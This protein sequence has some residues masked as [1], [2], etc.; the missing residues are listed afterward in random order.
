MALDQEYYEKALGILLTKGFSNQE[1]DQ[2]ATTLSVYLPM[3]F[4]K[5]G[6]WAL[7]PYDQHPADPLAFK[8]MRLLD[9]IPELKKPVILQMPTDFTYTTYGQEYCPGADA[10]TYTTGPD[11]YTHHPVGWESGIT[12]MP[13]AMGPAGDDNIEVSD[14][15]CDHPQGD[16]RLSLP[17]ES[18]VS[19]FTV[20]MRVG[21]KPIKMTLE[22][23]IQ[24]IGGYDKLPASARAAID[25][26]MEEHRNAPVTTVSVRTPLPGGVS[27]E[28]ADYLKLG[29]LSDIEGIKRA[30]PLIDEKTAERMSK[31]HCQLNQHIARVHREPRDVEV[32]DLLAGDHSQ[33]MFQSRHAKRQYP[34]SL[35][36]KFLPDQADIDEPEGM[37]VKIKTHS[38]RHFG[39]GLEISTPLFGQS[40]K[41]PTGP[42][43]MPGLEKGRDGKRKRNKKGRR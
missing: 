40:H 34:N 10:P 16:F 4:I 23:L 25:R 43:T 13:G 9:R 30:Y 37:T 1:A 29:D 33:R 18:M 5:A 2:I 20:V 21:G 22:E 14:L 32:F 39:H 15:T 27:Q 31:L 17:A 42:Q 8:H 28:Q 6:V 12:G 7:M 11:G 38:V 24:E 35:F 3:R 26:V 36:E 19:Q 41:N